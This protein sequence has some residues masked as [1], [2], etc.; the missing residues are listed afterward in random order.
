MIALN[1]DTQAALASLSEEDLITLVLHEIGENNERGARIVVAL[2]PSAAVDL[3]AALEIASTRKAVADR[4][5][6]ARLLHHF[7]ETISEL[8]P[9]LAEF[10]RRTH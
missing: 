4:E 3:Y 2:T 1:S 10:V 7:R 9:G 6:L 8:G 5:E